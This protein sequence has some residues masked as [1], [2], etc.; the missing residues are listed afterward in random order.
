M[1]YVWEKIRETLRTCVWEKIR[2]Y[3]LHNQP[4]R[5]MGY[6][7]MAW[8]MKYTILQLTQPLSSKN[9]LS[10]SGGMVLLGK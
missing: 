9:R 3:N 4:P 7:S 6:L 5:V 8:V 2:E 1:T 10:V